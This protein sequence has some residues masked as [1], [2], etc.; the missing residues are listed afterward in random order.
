MT[1]LLLFRVSQL[2]SVPVCCAF[3]FSRLLV[4]SL[5]LIIASLVVVGM[6]WEL[7]API[8]LGFLW[9]VHDF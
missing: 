1:L 4:L 6:S 8:F 5:T 7:C 3:F 2:L 9:Y